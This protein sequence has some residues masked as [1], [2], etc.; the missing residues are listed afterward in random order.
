[1]GL[2]G[3]V[4]L[5]ASLK[6]KSMERALEEV[7]T[8]NDQDKL[9]EAVLKSHYR[10]IK[11]A[12]LDRILDESVQYQKGQVIIFCPMIRS[13]F[14]LWRFMMKKLIF[15]I[16][17]CCLVMAAGFSV[18][19]E[20][21]VSADAGDADTIAVAEPVVTQVTDIEKYGNLVLAVSGSEVK[22]S[23]IDIGDLITVQLNGTD[24]EM[25]VVTNYSDVDQGAMLCRMVIK[26][27]TQEDYVLLSIN[28]GDLATWAG[29]ATRMDTEEAPG[30]VWQLND[31][32]P[33]PIPVV[34]TLKERDGYD[35]QLK[36][37]QLVRSDN[38]EDY[39]D[40]DD[41]AYANFRMISTTGMGEN[42]LYRSSSPINPGINR[43]KEADAASRD[44]GI[45]TFINLADSRGT[46]EA[47]EGFADTYY[48]TGQIICL[49]MVVDFQ[50]EDFRN[51][52]AKGFTFITQK[53]GPYLIHCNEGKDRAGFASAVLEAFMGA[54]SEEII[55]DYMVTYYNYYDVEPGTDL[56]AKI[57]EANICSSLSTAFD[58]ESLEDADLAAAARDYLISIG[59]SEETLTALFDKLSQNYSLKDE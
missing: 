49:N 6:G 35:E 20:S 25:P 30:F 13:G 17:M 14:G 39:P 4:W 43:N 48:S 53:E 40:L 7:R 57:A 8:L 31:G 29:L 46:M 19:A 58:L 16:W 55:Q 26:P 37:H 18:Y 56:Y 51:A 27:K 28:M 12:A 1:M 21:A 2:F 10:Q 24:Y 41:A 33:D 15:I 50:S 45:L 42:A 23:G 36:L 59:L 54:D 32:I 38:R 22:A 34:L 3:P 47:Y 11:E 52:L 44:A 5:K 9:R